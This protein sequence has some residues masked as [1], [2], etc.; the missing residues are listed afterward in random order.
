MMKATVII[1]ARFASTRLPGK[2]LLSETG[3]PLIQHVVESVLP[4]KYVERVVVAT[5]DDRIARAVR[6]GG[7]EAVLTRDDHT[8][9][10]DR[11]AE[12]AEALGLGDE[13]IVVNVQ[14]DEPDMPPV[15]VDE[16]ILT[17]ANGDSPMA[18]LCTPLSAADAENPNKVKV[19]F[20]TNGQAMYFSRSKIPHDRDGDGH[21]RY[22][23]HL[24]IY[25]YRVWFLKRFAGMAPTVC[26]QTE[27][28]EQLRVLENGHSIA[29]QVV[30]YDGG[31][32][33]T[34]QDYARFVARMK[35]S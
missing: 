27:K 30:Q 14:G 33:D 7:Y 35:T 12:A 22:Y 5:D 17:L 21:A 25:A 2:P 28:L 15:L 20:S 32:I 34:P 26:E 19:V 11:L 16:L 29:I 4:A 8:S 31:G 18:T 10:T 13:D 9:G 24:G 1:P 23:L 6:D 3:K